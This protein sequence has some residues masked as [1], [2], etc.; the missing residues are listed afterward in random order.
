MFAGLLVFLLLTYTS[1]A[2]GVTITSGGAS[3]PAPAFQS[4]ISD[5]NSIYNTFLNS[6]SYI[7]S[8]ST[9]GQKGTLSGQ[10]NFGGSDVAI[11]VAHTNGTYLVALP[12]IA[13]GLVISYNLPNTTQNVKLSRAVLP[14][15]FDGT[16]SQWNDPALVQDNAFLANVSK[17]ITVILRSSGSGA[18]LNLVRGLGLMDISSGYPNSPY[19]QPGFTLYINNALRA[20]TTTSAAII[21]G[22]VP[23][24]LTYLNQF[25]SL[26][27][28]STAGSN[29]KSALLQHANGEFISWSLNSLQLGVSGVNATAVTTLDEHTQALSVF[30][31]A[32]PG[33]YPFT[34]ISNFVI[35]YSNIS[36][37]YLT[38]VWTL[39]FLWFFMTN[40]K[41]ATDD[42]FISVYNTSVGQN[43]FDHLMEYKF[44]GGQLYGRSVCDPLITGGYMNPCVHGHCQDLLPFQEPTVQCV[45]EFGY[46]NINEATC[47][48][49]MPF[50][51]P[52]TITKI[53]QV[54]FGTGTFFLMIL[55][56]L[57][58]QNRNA[59]TIKA[60]SPLCCVNI[61]TGCLLGVLAIVFQAATETTVIC[62]LKVVIPSVAFGIVFRDDFLIGVSIDGILA[63]VY[64]QASQMAPGLTAFT[65]TNNQIWTCKASSG[66]EKTSATLLGVLFGFNALIMVLCLYIG[67]LTRKA[68][69]KFDESKQVGSMI[70]VSCAALLLA[71]AVD[72][73][74]TAET[75]HI[76]NLHK[77]T[78]SVAIWII[79]IVSPII[80]FV[81]PLVQTV[82]GEKTSAMQASTYN[83]GESSSIVNTEK[84]DGQVK[85]HMFHV[86]I[87]PNRA[88]ALWKSAVMMAMPEIDML[89][90]LGDQY[91]GT[92]VFTHCNA[93]VIE[94]TTV[95]AKKA[96]EESI[97]LT[98]GSNKTCYVVEFPSKDRLD[99]FRTLKTQA[100]GF[101]KRDAESGSRSG[102]KESM[103]G[104]ASM[105]VAG[106]A[107]NSLT[108]NARTKRSG[109]QTSQY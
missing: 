24:T 64:V 87:R 77:L 79:C 33:A 91:S 32:A 9:T 78:G 38:T 25:E 48:E 53:Q 17:P 60:I 36:S 103:G 11:N 57:V 80:L 82:Q 73:G 39:K 21:V 71:L 75:S 50:F 102:H 14:R 42:N 63:W 34:I 1:N 89:I 68:A 70:Y 52:S 4:A 35:N 58:F 106:S 55:I 83:A 92:Y 62:Y 98:V 51:V 94:K 40:T 37:D 47:V 90:I 84:N 26:H 28:T 95:A 41:Y 104:S 61:L 19:L 67:Q 15:I 13:G 85:A 12:A 27:E 88:T 109:S 49:P 86:G 3:F 20:A 6:F 72:Y 22:G 7:S 97:E 29:C 5:F 8:D 18:S 44:N 100:T 30:D 16:I 2:Q 31:T 23:Y 43:T 59:P 56:C 99:E 108:P 46:Q 66:Y 107:T 54:L 96:P 45:C 10:F 65:D 105:I 69:A 81:P 76:F 74:L 93:K 101:K